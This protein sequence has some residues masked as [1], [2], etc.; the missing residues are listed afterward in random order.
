MGKRYG[1]YRNLYPLKSYYEQFPFNYIM[2]FVFLHKIYN[3]INTKAESLNMSI[4]L[5]DS[6]LLYSSLTVNISENYFY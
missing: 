3:F 4:C 6:L 2:L 1:S 5:K